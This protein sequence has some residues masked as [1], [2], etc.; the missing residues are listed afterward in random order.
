MSLRM[1]PIA[2]ASAAMLLTGCAST[3]PGWDA[4]FG[5]ATRQVR[6]GQM[7]DPGA[8]ARHANALGR[9]DAKAVAGVHNAY[10]DSYG[11]A[12][13]EVKAPIFTFMT[14]GQ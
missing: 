12:V 6:L 13:K 11:Y 7:H 14:P 8:T 5:D 4:R 2:A 9:T 3:S 10:A 1:T